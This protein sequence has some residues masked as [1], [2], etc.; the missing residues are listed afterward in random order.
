MD[1]FQLL[2][3]PAG[4]DCNLNCTYCFYRPVSKLFFPH[5]SHRMK[6]KVLEEVI[7][8]YMALRFPVSVFSWQGGEPTLCGLSFF[9]DVVKLQI[10]YG[11]NGQLVSNAFQTNG[12]LLDQD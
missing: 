4:P 1:S 12:I 5:T 11:S 9:Q 6:R 7:R 2:I 3:K 10:K 8:Q